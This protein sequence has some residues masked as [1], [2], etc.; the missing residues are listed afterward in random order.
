[1]RAVQVSR[2]GGPEVLEVVDLEPPRPA[3]GQVLVDV[4]RGRRQ[5]R[6][7]AP[8]RG[9]LPAPAAAAVRARGRGRRPRGGTHDGERVVALLGGG[10]GYA[11][12]AAAT[13][14]GGLPV[15][16][17]DLRRRGAR[18]RAAGH[19][20]LAPAAHLRPAQPGESVVVHAAAGGVGTLAV[21]LAKQWGAGRVIATASSP[22][23][24]EL[25]LRARRGR[26]RRRL[27]DD[28]GR[29]GPRP[30]AGG[31]RR[32]RRRHRA[33]DDRR[34]R[35]RRL[36][37]RARAARPARRLRPGVADAA[38]PV[39]PAGLMAHSPDRGRF[40]AHARA[41]GRPAVS[42]RRWTSSSRSCGPAGCIRS[43]AG[44]IR[45]SPAREAHEALLRRGTTGK[46]VLTVDR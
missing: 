28:D 20:R 17:G 41:P 36:A 1:M 8:G 23:K 21:Q 30:A 29:R 2:F 38:E 22:E 27:G 34:A 24:R 26:R 5:L 35:L 10:G 3:P 43:S 14:G 7:H 44:A 6:R 46:L 16:D 12:Q 19:H 18:A 39:S 11:E 42:S 15:P 31:Q 32:S 25:A 4:D 45:W 40:L 33:G 9:H 37:G 13:R